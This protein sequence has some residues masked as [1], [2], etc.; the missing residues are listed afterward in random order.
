MTIFNPTSTNQFVNLPL[1]PIDETNSGTT[2]LLGVD[3]SGLLFRVP[4][5]NLKD[6]VGVNYSNLVTTNTEKILL[7]RYETGGG[8]IQE[9]ELGDNLVLDFNTGLL[10]STISVIDEAGG[11]LEG[12]YPSPVIK[13]NVVTIDKLEQ[14][15][16]NII[17]SRGSEGLGDVEKITLGP[18]FT[19]DT[20]TNTLGVTVTG[21]TIVDTG[22]IIIDRS[23]DFTANPTS[24][25][26][27]DSPS[28]GSI[29][30][31][32]PSGWAKGEQ[33]AVVNS[34]LGNV[35]IQMP[36]ELLSFH[37]NGI[38]TVNLICDGNDYFYN[39]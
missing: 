24:M 6:F 4:L 8:T 36:N 3:N 38:R 21:G 13:Q 19:I 29:L 16:D 2:N 5:D 17:F 15:E 39:F 33:I 27:V 7:G 37:E 20:Q 23:I 11:D 35:V 12:F 9:I 1:L 32:I 30:V 31:T 25:Y 10:D 14:V 18:E 26:F 28:E 22:W 34:G